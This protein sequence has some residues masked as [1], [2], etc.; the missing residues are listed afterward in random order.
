[1]DD[2]KLAQQHFEVVSVQNRYSVLDR[3]WESVLDY[4]KSQHIAF[5][6]WFPIGG[7]MYLTYTGYQQ[8]NTPGRKHSGDSYSFICRRNA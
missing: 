5:I 1:M 6:P 7:G 3:Q 2:I 4:C 8:R